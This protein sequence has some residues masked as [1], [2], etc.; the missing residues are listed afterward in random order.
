MNH[1]RPDGIS[2]KFAWQPGTI[3]TASEQA[4]SGPGGLSSYCLLALTVKEISL[5]V[6]VRRRGHYSNCFRLYLPAVKTREKKYAR[7]G[8]A[9]ILS[10]QARARKNISDFIF[11]VIFSVS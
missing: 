5:L 3:L 9:G 10:T 2:G 1:F 6:Q 11:S 8:Q 4:E 7:T